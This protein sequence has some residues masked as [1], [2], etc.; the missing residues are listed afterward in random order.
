MSQL[1]SGAESWWHKVMR[2]FKPAKPAAPAAE[3]EPEAELCHGGHVHIA[4]RGASDDRMYM[5]YSRHW[6]EVKFFRP[7]GLRVFCKECRRR[8]L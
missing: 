6:N 5:A 8:L 2:V 3:A 1:S 4:Y 7:I